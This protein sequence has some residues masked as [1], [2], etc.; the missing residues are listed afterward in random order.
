MENKLSVYCF[1]ND[2][3]KFKEMCKE[4]G[5]KMNDIIREY[6]KRKIRQWESE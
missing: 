6:I 4:R 2:K 3:Q 5:Y 1:P